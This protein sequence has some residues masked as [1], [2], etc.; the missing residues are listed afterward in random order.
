M[1]E[2]GTP[3]GDGAVIDDRIAARR[4]EVRRDRQRRRKRRTIT[5]AV[6]LVVLA[7]LYAVERS[8][9]VGLEEV[10]VVGVD[11]LA[12]DEIREAAGLELGTSTLRL[13]LGRAEA[14]VEALPAVREA[15][16]S[17]TD[18]LTVR[19]EVTE[20]VPVL[21]V[22]GDGPS[23]L[24]DRDGVVLAEGDQDGLPRV[25]IEG[26]PPA[27]GEE[28][29]ADPALANAFAAWRGL[30]GPLR[31]EVVRLR[32]DG[33]TELTLRLRD[34]LDV[35]FGRAERIAEKVRALG[36]ILEDIGDAEVSAIDV[37]AP[38]APFVVP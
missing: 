13:Q 8:P 33:P 5:V 36:A 20:R 15:E 28:V 35:R 1:S 31:A 34:G 12:A 38:A 19:I 3:A 9:L 17:R 26:T 23:V 6:T 7:L 22:R 24:V 25:R 18:P 2:D 16:A 14:R 11:R 29:D 10:V 21:E 32:A 30:S 4:R 27:P 37:R